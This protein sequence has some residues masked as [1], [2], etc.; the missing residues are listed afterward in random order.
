MNY[1]RKHNHFGYAAVMTLN[2]SYFLL[3]FLV[4]II[5]IMK[6][7]TANTQAILTHTKHCSNMLYINSFNLH[8]NHK[9]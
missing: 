7:A 6:I 4:V 2:H 9:M 8:N 1:P 5:I 3:N